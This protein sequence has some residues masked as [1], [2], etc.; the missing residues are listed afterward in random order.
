[1]STS[2]IYT[3]LTNRPRVELSP[4]FVYDGLLN[5]AIAN[6]ASIH[7]RAVLYLLNDDLDSAIRTAKMGDSD[8][9]LLLYTIGIALRRKLDM[10][11]MQVFKRLSIMR[12]P[13]LEKVYSKVTFDKVIQKVFDLEAV[14]NARARKVVEEIQL[15]EL[16]LLYE[17]AQSQ[18]QAQ[19]QIQP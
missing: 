6:V 10:E 3:Q 7:I 9:N 18:S 19:T 13:L 12:Y 5:K 1:M 2:F 8:D 14:D 15:N 17:C 16:K 4:L 11:S